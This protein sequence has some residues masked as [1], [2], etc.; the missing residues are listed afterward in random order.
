MPLATRTLRFWHNAWNHIIYTYTKYSPVA[1]LK[2][3]EEGYTEVR[4]QLYRMEEGGL[5]WFLHSCVVVFIITTCTCIPNH[6]E[7]HEKMTIQ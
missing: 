5:T 1:L 6:F 3:P 2:V 7:I 4:G